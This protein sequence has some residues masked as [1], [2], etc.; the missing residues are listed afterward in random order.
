MNSV[1]NSSSTG[2]ER[3]TRRLLRRVI[4]FHIGVDLFDLLAVFAKC[5][6]L[7]VG[8][9]LIGVVLG[10]F[11]AIYGFSLVSTN[12]LELFSLK[13]FALGLALL[14]EFLL[15]QDVLSPLST[16]LHILGLLLASILFNHLGMVELTGFLSL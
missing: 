9:T 8:E 16:G 14:T 15:L 1:D 3:L 12:M 7:K 5:G 10:T 4:L 11:T 2:I 6:C 13:V